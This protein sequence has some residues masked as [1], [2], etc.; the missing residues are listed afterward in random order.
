MLH[1]ITLFFLASARFSNAGEEA[2]HL[3]VG[4]QVSHDGAVHMEAGG[5][6]STMIS[7]EEVINA[8]T[9]VSDEVAL[10]PKTDV[11]VAKVYKVN[12]NEFLE[13]MKGD[14]AAMEQEKWK[15][16]ETEKHVW[17]SFK[18]ETCESSTYYKLV[19]YTEVRCNYDDSGYNDKTSGWANQHRGMPGFADF[20]KF[21]DSGVTHQI[22]LNG[23][24][25]QVWGQSQKKWCFPASDDVVKQYPQLKGYLIY[26]GKVPTKYRQMPPINV[27]TNDAWTVQSQLEISDCK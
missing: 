13:K 18:L 14:G 9:N 25:K 7:D 8:A 26:P 19:R 6:E 3:S 15:I 22:D 4:V 10:E 2:S 23:K 21:R 27:C 1:L 17:K 16:G 5:Q 11:F 24:V 20:A 12:V